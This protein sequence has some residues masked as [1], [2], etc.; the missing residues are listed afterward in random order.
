M[1]STFND[2]FP[3]VLETTVAD[4]QHKQRGEVYVVTLDTLTNSLSRTDAHYEST[5]TGKGAH[6]A[7][8]GRSSPLRSSRQSCKASISPSSKGGKSG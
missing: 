8:E 2:G 5:D 4:N 1:D 3:D 6:L 7:R